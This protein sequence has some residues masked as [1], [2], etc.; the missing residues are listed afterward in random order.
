MVNVGDKMTVE[1]WDGGVNSPIHLQC[2]LPYTRL[3]NKNVILNGCVGER[4]F[5]TISAAVSAT[6]NKTR[7]WPGRDLDLQPRSSIYPLPTLI[8]KSVVVLAF[9]D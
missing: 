8:N 6:P 9:L 4:D 2:S 3:I 1:V 5:V 7:T